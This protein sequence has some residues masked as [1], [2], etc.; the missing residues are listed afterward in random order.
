MSPAYSQYPNGRQ[1]LK[2]NSREAG[3][4]YNCVHLVNTQGKKYHKINT[5]FLSCNHRRLTNRLSKALKLCQHFINYIYNFCTADVSVTSWL[6]QI[7]CPG[8]FERIQ[9]IVNSDLSRICKHCGFWV[10]CQNSIPRGRVC[11]CKHHTHTYI[12]SQRKC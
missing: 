9:R 5:P 8:L 6:S 10:Y 3:R 2:Q 11:P 1:R 7:A 12:Q 4:A